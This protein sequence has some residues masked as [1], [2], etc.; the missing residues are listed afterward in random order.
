M[1]SLSEH[2]L[3]VAAALLLLVAPGP[4]AR[5]RT[6]GTGALR[7]CADPNSLPYSNDRQEGFE[8]RIA[9]LVARDLGRRLAYVWW[10][11]RRGFIRKT[12]NAG[13]CD[14]IIGLPSNVDTALTTRPYYRSGYVF[15]T[16]SERR[17]ELHSLDDPR[18]RRLKIGVQIIGADYANAPPAHALANRGLVDNVKGYAVF[19]GFSSEMRQRRIIDAVARGAVDA[20]IVWGPT[21][22]YF[23][24]RSRVP[25]TITPFTPEIDLP[26]LPFVFDI[27]MAVRRGEGG[28]RDEL[29]AILE[30]RQRQIDAI[31]R[32]YGVP[33]FDAMPHEVAP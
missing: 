31:L 5:A 17:L 24:R 25:L 16:R 11:Q 12:L 4:G 1:S 6:A 27:S 20:G 13:L 26:F 21:A 28:L 18:L 29:D 19:P 33:R 30:R 8:N 10:P 9:Q 15:V 2:A 14:V 3:P 23:A 32:S 22:G 7:V